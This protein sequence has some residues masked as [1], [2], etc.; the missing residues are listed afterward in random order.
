M[1]DQGRCPDPKSSRLCALEEPLESKQQSSTAM[2]K[3]HMRLVSKLNLNT[4][5]QKRR[6]NKAILKNPQAGHSAS[7]RRSYLQ[8]QW[9]IHQEQMELFAKSSDKLLKHQK[10]L[11]RQ[12][13]WL[14]KNRK[15]KYDT[16]MARKLVEESQRDISMFKG[17]RL[18]KLSN[19]DPKTSSEKMIPFLLSE[20]DKSLVKKLKDLPDELSLTIFNM[21]LQGFAEA[22]LK[23][24]SKLITEFSLQFKDPELES[25]SFNSLTAWYYVFHTIDFFLQNEFITQ[26]QH[27]NILQEYK[28]F[29]ELIYYTSNLFKIQSGAKLDNNLLALTKHWYWSSDKNP[30]SDLRSKG[31]E[32]VIEFVSILERIKQNVENLTKHHPKSEDSFQRI[33][34]MVSSP[35]YFNTYQNIHG[36]NSPVSYEDGS[37]QLGHQGLTDPKGF[38]SA[39]QKFI[40]QVISHSEIEFGHFF[41]M[42]EGQIDVCVSICYILGFI[43][44]DLSLGITK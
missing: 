20:K 42:N 43:E 34:N 9:G 13:K 19:L 32:R 35:D 7:S 30:F 26:E 8:K 27:R 39:T 6:L 2:K 25:E 16:S 36:S 37:V 28:M 1:G 3:F 18:L 29:R 44:R 38:I 33:S 10:E 5:G 23:K 4:L 17:F 41:V 24:L 31:Q 40:H 11:K 15:N 12:L 22:S 21:A 14:R